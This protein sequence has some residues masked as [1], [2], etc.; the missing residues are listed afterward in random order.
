MATLKGV[1]SLFLS[2]LRVVSSTPPIATATYSKVP[3]GV[4]Q[5]LALAQSYDL[6][7]WQV[8]NPWAGLLEIHL[9]TLSILPALPLEN[10]SE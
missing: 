2:D 10:L 6:Y 4:A 8:T 3:Y 5:L 1:C 9:K 7:L